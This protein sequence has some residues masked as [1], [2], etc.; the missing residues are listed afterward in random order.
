MPLCKSNNTEVAIICKNKLIKTFLPFTSEVGV[1]VGSGIK[2][3]TTPKN[4]T[5][6]KNYMNEKIEYL[7]RTKMGED[8]IKEKHCR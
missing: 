4:I 5:P 7:I 6:A 1:S 3:A 2:L 8:D